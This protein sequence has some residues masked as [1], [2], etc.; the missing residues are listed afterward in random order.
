MSDMV[1]AFTINQDDGAGAGTLNRS[2]SG[3]WRDQE[4]TLVAELAGSYAWYLL[5]KPGGSAAT[6]SG[7]SSDTATITPDVNGTY[8]IRLVC[9]RSV[10]VRVFR[11]TKDSAGNRDGVWALPAFGEGPNDD[12]EG[13]N[14]RGSTP[15]MEAIFTD[16]WTGNFPGV[17]GSG[18][19]NFVIYTQGG[20]DLLEGEYGTFAEAL[21]AAQALP[22]IVTLLVNGDE[23]PPAIPAGT[24]NLERRIRLVGFTSLS[25]G[26]ID[27]DVSSGG[28]LQNAFHVEN[29]NLVG[30]LGNPLFV[31]S[32]GVQDLTF[33]RSERSDVPEGDD[34]IT[35]GTG[36]NTLR[37]IESSFSTDGQAIV[38]PSLGKD[39]VVI[40]ERDSFFNTEC[41]HGTAGE[42]YLRRDGTSVI[43]ATG[44]SGTLVQQSGAT[45]SFRFQALAGT[46]GSDPADGTSWTTVGTVYIDP[47]T[48]ANP[49]F[50]TRSWLFHADV[51]VAEASAGTVQSK[52][53]LVDA[54]LTALGTITSTLGGAS[55]FPQHLSAV[56]TA[57]ASNGQVRSTGTVYLVQL[58]RQGGSVGDVAF[59][60][61]AFV[62]VS[63]S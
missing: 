7:A 63:W 44:F 62:E 38:S 51:E 12:N 41:F 30:E 15:T 18:S 57:G 50:T 42:L 21:T 2:R 46:V 35:L 10:S 56:L 22:G 40:A 49:Q 34:L 59:V 55:T 4:V 58:Q 43:E 48:L 13:G 17:A 6:L 60:H 31:V 32:S 54:S 5:D 52:V 23:D 61:N 26:A 36:T 53:R 16:I 25:T 47:D 20:V 14:E 27:L 9:G 8:M 19:S 39:L 1:A 24:H 37:A 45:R 29:L 11:V 3:L 28:Q 33:V